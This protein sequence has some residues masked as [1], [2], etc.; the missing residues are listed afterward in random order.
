M[1]EAYFVGLVQPARNVT[2][3]IST[4]SVG[5]AEA[6]NNL[7]KRSVLLVRNI[8]G[9]GNRASI[10]FGLGSAVANTGVI[11]EDGES[12]SDT[13]ETTYECYQGMITAIGSAVGTILSI[14][15][16]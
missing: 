10:S 15:E 7:N 3:T 14:F 4:S 5:I 16:R 6:R 13:S 9:N 8:S 2:Q 12:F 1:P 11:L